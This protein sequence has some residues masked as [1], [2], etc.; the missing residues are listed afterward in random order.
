MCWWNRCKTGLWAALIFMILSCQNSESSHEFQTDLIS[1]SRF[2]DSFFLEHDSIRSVV[3][4]L[5]VNEGVPETKEIAGY[6]IYED[7]KMVKDFDVAT[8]RWADFFEITKTEIGG[9]EKLEYNTLNEKAPAGNLVF[10]LDGD[11]IRSISIRSR[12]GTMISEQNTDIDWTPGEGYVLRSQSKLLFQ[13]P[14]IFE[15]EVRYDNVK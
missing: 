7:L 10:L 2:V 6:N 13:K 3:K 12:K 5:T 11:S 9:V 15:M 1:T 14:R 4:T 8:P